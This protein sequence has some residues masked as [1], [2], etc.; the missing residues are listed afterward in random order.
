M[1]QRDSIVAFGNW[2]EGYCMARLDSRGMM[3]PVVEHIYERFKHVRIDGPPEHLQEAVGFQ[4]V[5]QD[6]GDEWYDQGRRKR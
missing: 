5:P 4:L 1:S 2:L 6:D 3:D